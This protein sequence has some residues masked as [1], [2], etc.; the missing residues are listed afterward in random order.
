M[1]LIIELLIR[2]SKMPISTFSRSSISATVSLEAAILAIILNVEYLTNHMDA[3]HPIMS[4]EVPE[5]RERA[6]KSACRGQLLNFREGNSILTD[7]EELNDGQKL[8]VRWRGP[9]RII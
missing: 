2:E 8:D 4:K 3:S 9:R 7:R 5:N 6:R 1:A